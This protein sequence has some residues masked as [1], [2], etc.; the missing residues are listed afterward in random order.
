MIDLGSEVNVMT[1]AYIAKLGLKV[2]K[3]DSRVQKVYGSTLDTFGIVLAD[4]QVEDKLGRA[5]FFQETFLVANTTLEMILRI[6]FLTFH[7]IDV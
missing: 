4:F 1:L 5:G 7:N 2:Q 3:T 6:P